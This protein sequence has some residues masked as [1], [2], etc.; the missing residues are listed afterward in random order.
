M[1][2]TTFFIL[3]N[4]FTVFYK[5]DVSKFLT[6]CT[7]RFVGPSPLR[8][9][10]TWDS[11]HQHPD[12][13]RPLSWLQVYLQ[14]QDPQVEGCRSRDQ[15]SFDGGDGEAR[16][17]SNDDLRKDRRCPLLSYSRFSLSLRGILRASGFHDITKKSKVYT[18]Q[19]IIGREEAGSS[20]VYLSQLWGMRSQKLAYSCTCI[21]YYTQ[22]D[23]LPLF[24]SYARMKRISWDERACELQYGWNSPAVEAE[25]RMLQP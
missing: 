5:W 18:F 21:V 14:D 9:P 2:W 16:D 1:F 22:V 7:W 17:P 20:Q 10:L 15:H 25:S 12:I 8:G 11:R 19:T 6:S 3:V 23:I 24:L 4:G 13:H